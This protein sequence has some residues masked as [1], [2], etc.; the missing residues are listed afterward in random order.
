MGLEFENLPGKLGKLKKNLNED[1]E[2]C[3]ECSQQN[4]AKKLLKV[5]YNVNFVPKNGKMKK[6][7]I[8]S[9]R[10]GHILK[11]CELTSPRPFLDAARLG[12]T[13]R[14]QM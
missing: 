12:Y 10:W 9:Q 13:H 14:I 1:W 5:N 3:M 2:D 4:T 7:K 11:R 6:G 8:Y